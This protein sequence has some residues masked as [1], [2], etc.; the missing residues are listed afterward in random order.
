MGSLDAYEVKKNGNFSYIYDGDYV[1]GA[2]YY[3]SYMG[4]FHAECDSPQL[5]KSMRIY[6]DSS[7]HQMKTFFTNKKE[8]KNAIIK[9]CK[10]E[11]I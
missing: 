9:Y 7:N 4:E 1:V 3:A 2:Y 5:S 11:G 10:K 6:K 8:A